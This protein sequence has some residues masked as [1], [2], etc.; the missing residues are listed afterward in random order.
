[1][2]NTHCSPGNI[3]KKKEHIFVHPTKKYTLEGGVRHLSPQYGPKPKMDFKSGPDT[4]D[5]KNHMSKY[6][7]L[8]WKRGR[9]NNHYDLHT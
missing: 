4:M 7:V 1:M 2:Q 8:Q 9:Y 3:I 5:T 6:I